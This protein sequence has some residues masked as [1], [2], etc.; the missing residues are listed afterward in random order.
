MLRV[1]GRPE[2]VGSEPLDD[3]VRGL[4]GRILGL[5]AENPEALYFVGLG[6]AQA[7]DAAAAVV[8][9][10]RLLT[11]LEPASQAY[12]VVEEG[13]ERHRPTQ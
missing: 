13:L 4:Y 1:P 5:D 8:H 2:F 9:W 7:G 12:R 10:E 3:Q 6:E 11:L